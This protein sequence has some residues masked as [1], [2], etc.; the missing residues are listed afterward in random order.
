MPKIEILAINGWELPSFLKYN[1]VNRT[2]Y[3][4]CNETGV[5][6]VDFQFT[7]DQGVQTFS[8]IKLTVLPANK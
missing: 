8:N 3:G 6:R 1:P 7:D 2:L 4:F 5:F